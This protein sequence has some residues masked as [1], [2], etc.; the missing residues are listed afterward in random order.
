MQDVHVLSLLHGELRG[1]MA[2]HGSPSSPSHTFLAGS[3]CLIQAA[4]AASLPQTWQV[5]TRAPPHPSNNHAMPVAY[6]S[7]G[8]M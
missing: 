6:W 2:G 5:P 1:V 8:Q 3:L 7:M 4:A